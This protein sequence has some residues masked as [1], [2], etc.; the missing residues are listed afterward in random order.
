[1]TVDGGTGPRRVLLV[2]D[3]RVSRLMMRHMLATLGH[4]PTDAC[5]VLSALAALETAPYDA[6]VSD[7]LLPDGTGLD[8]LDRIWSMTPSPAFLLVTGVTERDTIEDP[9]LERVDVYLTKPVSTSDLARSL[10]AA[11]APGAR[12]P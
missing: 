1:M 11:T 7:L 8:V 9:R 4:D 2:E 5:D 3:D 10:R 12:V 6:V